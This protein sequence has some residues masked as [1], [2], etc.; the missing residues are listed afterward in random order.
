MKNTEGP[1]VEFLKSRNYPYGFVP[2]TLDCYKTSTA[3][4]DHTHK[5]FYFI[6]P[7][8]RK[9]AP[10]VIFFNGGPGLAVSDMFEQY[11]YESFLPGY[12][13]IFFDQRG[14]GLSFGPTNNNTDLRFFTSRHI[15][16]DAEQIRKKVLGLD[17]KWII[18]GQSFGGTV[19]RKYLQFFPDGV[20]KA[21]THGSGQYDPVSVTVFTEKILMRNWEAYF[22]KYPEHFNLLERMKEALTENDFIQGEAYKLAGKDLIHLLAFYLTISSE[23]D[24]FAF[25]K[26]LD[27]ENL[28]D[29]YIQK[30]TPLAKTIFRAGKVN[31]VVGFIDCTNGMT[32]E[33]INLLAY[34]QVLDSPWYNSKYPSKMAFDEAV[35]PTLEDFTEIEDLMKRHIFLADNPDLIK[36]L[37]NTSNHGF[38][39]YVFGSEADPLAHEAVRQEEL[40][41]KKFGPSR[42][43]YHYST[44][45]HREWLTNPELFKDILN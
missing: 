39:F 26:E 7:A 35:V 31:R 33:E 3:Q 24:V 14:N 42:I 40:I 8:N 30:I 45:H 15:A 2:T 12:N 5:V 18:F 11:K 27:V 20:S 25:F 6:R 38:D 13:V 29:S 22:K 34:P 23:K 43:Q 32:D 4:A 19:A 37:E 17:A 28:S 9:N 21:I 44:G 41:V 1:F 16:Y 36:I 10:Y